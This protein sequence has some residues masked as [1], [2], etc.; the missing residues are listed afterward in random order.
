M[1]DRLR[2]A[3]A[4]LHEAQKRTPSL[5]NVNFDALLGPNEENSKREADSEFGVNGDA[6]AQS[7]KQDTDNH[8]KLESMMDSYGHMNL[9]THGGMERDFYGAAS[10]LAWIQKAG[11]YFEG[12]D[13]KDHVADEVSVG[14][15]AA[16]QLFDAPL[17]PHRAFNLDVSVEDLLPPRDTATNLLNVV[18]TQVYPLFHFLCE[19]EF[20]ESTDRIYNRH[21]DDYH[22]NDQSFLPLFYLVMALGYLFSR[23]EHRDHGCRVAVAQA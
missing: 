6:D 17:P 12:S 21:P 8:D 23:N 7:A 5:A 15:T 22:E 1:E 3:R 14:D 18:F 13:S 2:R 10:G 9:N 16:V 19:E 4:Y 20:Q 11:H